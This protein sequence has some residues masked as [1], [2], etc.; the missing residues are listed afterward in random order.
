VLRQVL[1]KDGVYLTEAARAEAGAVAGEQK[2]G[3]ARE[4]DVGAMLGFTGVSAQ[5]LAIATRQ[6]ATLDLRRDF[7]WSRP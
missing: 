4:V 6:L 3:L 7:R 5:D 1:R 2:T